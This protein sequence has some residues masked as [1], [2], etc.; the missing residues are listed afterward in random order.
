M[1]RVGGVTHH[2]RYNERS[3]IFYG[4]K[5]DLEM[6]GWI[7]SRSSFFYYFI[8]LFIENVQKPISSVFKWVIL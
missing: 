6:Q 8:H 4:E 1:E 5:H 3:F 7:K 2:G